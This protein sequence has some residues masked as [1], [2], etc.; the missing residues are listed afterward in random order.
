[1]PMYFL[2][3]GWG[4]GDRVYAAMKF[5]LFTMFGSAFMLVGSSRRR[6]C[7]S[8]AAGGPLTFDLVAIADEPR[9]SR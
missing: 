7:I 6:C 1:M 8:T 2:I 3:G 4:Y 9:A 5:F